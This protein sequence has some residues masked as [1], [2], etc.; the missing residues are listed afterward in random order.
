MSEPVPTLHSTPERRDADFEDLDTTRAE[1]DYE[2][3]VEEQAAA[4]RAIAGAPLDAVLL[5]SDGDEL[6]L[7]FV[8]IH[9]IGE[10]GRHNGHAD[11]IRQ[12]ID[13]RT[14]S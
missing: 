12:R 14:G 5:D 7:R 1:A 10:Y 13:G 2:R 11:L 8:L 6:S 4:R 3:L 9:M